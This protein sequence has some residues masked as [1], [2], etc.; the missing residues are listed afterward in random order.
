MTLCRTL[1]SVVTRG[2]PNP[3]RPD[4]SRGRQGAVGATVR[5]TARKGPGGSVAAALTR[6]DARPCLSDARAPRP[7]ERPTHRGKPDTPAPTRGSRPARP[8]APSPVRNKEPQTPTR[9]DARPMDIAR[10]EG[11]RVTGPQKERSSTPRGSPTSGWT[12]EEGPYWTIRAAKRGAPGVSE[13]GREETSR[14]GGPNL[15]GQRESDRRG[16]RLRGG[17]PGLHPRQAGPFLAST[18][19][20][21]RPFRTGCGPGGN[22]CR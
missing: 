21:R 2:L 15:L 10:V 6:R 16:A 4:A 14:G 20:G 17:G 5:A 12:E 8:H 18:R 3:A 19:P 11:T 13:S 22:R 1:R 7:Q 9:T